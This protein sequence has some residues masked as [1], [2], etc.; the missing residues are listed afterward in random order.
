MRSA[1]TR[2]LRENWPNTT[3]RLAMTRP[4]GP[5][6][7]AWLAAKSMAASKNIL[8]WSVVLAT[9]GSTK[10]VRNVQ[11]QRL[12]QIGH[13]NRAG[14]PTITPGRTRLGAEAANETNS[15]ASLRRKENGSARGGK[16]KTKTKNNVHQ[17]HKKGGDARPHL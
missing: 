1:S 11:V 3:R 9:C 12:G 14:P 15:K 5:V 10:N 2:S 16:N 13:S 4:P 17:Q 8:W 6:H 7:G